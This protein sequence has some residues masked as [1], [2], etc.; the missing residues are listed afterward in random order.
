VGGTGHFKGLKGAGFLPIKPV[1]PTDRR[2][3]V[4]GE[5]DQPLKVIAGAAK[6]A[7][8]TKTGYRLRR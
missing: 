6:T 7:D 2:H 1:F 4:D 3:S 8:A 5:I